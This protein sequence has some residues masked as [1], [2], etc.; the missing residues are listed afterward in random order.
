M[1]SKLNH[2]KKNKIVRKII[3]KTL[4]IKKQKINFLY[5]FIVNFKLYLKLYNL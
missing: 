2:D 5:C 4:I 1:D 3:K